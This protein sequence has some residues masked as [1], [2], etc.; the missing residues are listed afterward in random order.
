MTVYSLKSSQKSTLLVCFSS[1]LFIGCSSTDGGGE[2][3]F[4]L[5]WTLQGSAGAA[6]CASHDIASVVVTT[7]DSDSGEAH[8][9]TAPCTE[10]GLTTMD[11][12]QGN[13]EI[14]LEAMG[15]QGELAGTAT[16][17]KVLESAG[18]VVLD[19][20]SITVESPT[21]SFRPRWVVRSAGQPSD[22]AAFSSAGVS[23]T[24]IPMEGSA[25]TDIYFCEDQNVDP[26]PIPL[27]PFS[28][29][30]ELLGPNDE[31][32]VRTADVEFP[33]M[34]GLREHEFVLDVP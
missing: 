8:S 25:Q 19:S 15:S 32:V 16:V 23:V 5:A 31:V 4:V 10:A 34:R 18:E 12:A 30:A 11:L 7:K 24:R 20:V 28:A 2:G 26:L 27:G 6:N 21:A 3:R 22:C 1:M 13:Y 33:A 29:F 9:L 14:K 17:S